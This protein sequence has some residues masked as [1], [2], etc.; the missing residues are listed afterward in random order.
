MTSSESSSSVGVD[1]V[2]S[3]YHQTSH[4][5]VRLPLA[6]Q[7]DHQNPR[8]RKKSAREKASNKSMPLWSTNLSLRFFVWKGEGFRWPFLQPTVFPFEPHHRLHLSRLLD[9]ILSRLYPSP[10]ALR[11]CVFL[12][13][14]YVCPLFMPLTLELHTTP[15]QSTGSNPTTRDCV[16]SRPPLTSL[17]SRETIELSHLAQPTQVPLG[18][19]SQ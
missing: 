7:R 3:V 11:S 1:I 16:H 18:D 12:I 15:C 19:S 6:A 13:K 5:Q 17:L 8:L 14:I 4:K 10:M 2:R 9:F